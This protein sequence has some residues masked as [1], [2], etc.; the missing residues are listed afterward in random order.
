[1]KSARQ[2]RTGTQTYAMGDFRAAGSHKSLW[3][4]K[5]YLVPAKA[6]KIESNYLRPCPRSV[7][8]GQI[9]LMSCGKAAL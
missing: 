3:H 8:V 5:M 6:D 4:S 2:P 7:Q 9:Q 1:M